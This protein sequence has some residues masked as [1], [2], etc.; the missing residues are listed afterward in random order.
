M[1]VKSCLFMRTVTRDDVNAPYGKCI[2]C[3]CK[4]RSHV[5][6]PAEYEIHIAEGR[7]GP[8]HNRNQS[9]SEVNDSEVFE[10]VVGPKVLCHKCWLIKQS[11]GEGY[12]CE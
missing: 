5:L 2:D 11:K 6:E 8:A 4:T 10:M 9:H 3:G 7:M 1:R 12:R